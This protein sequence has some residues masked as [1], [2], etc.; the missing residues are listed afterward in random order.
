MLNYFENAPFYAPTIQRLVERAYSVT[1]VN[2]S[3]SVHIWDVL[4]ICI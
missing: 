1:P 4:A 2:P 3:I